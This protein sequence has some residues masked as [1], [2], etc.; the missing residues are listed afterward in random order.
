MGVCAQGVTQCQ[1]DGTVSCAPL[2]K[3]TSESCD[4]LDNNCDGMVDNG[5][6][7][8]DGNKVCF[9]GTCGPPAGS[10]SSAASP[11]TAA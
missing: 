5:T 7:L 8:C 9:N 6:G 2:V 4:N 11:V 3:P 1:L 10:K